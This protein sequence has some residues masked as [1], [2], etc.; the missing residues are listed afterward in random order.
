MCDHE[1]AW[2]GDESDRRSTTQKNVSDQ[3]WKEGPSWCW[4]YRL[5]GYCLTGT[6]GAHPVKQSRLLMIVGLSESCIVVAVSGS[7]FGSRDVSKP[8]LFERQWLVQDGWDG[9]AKVVSLSRG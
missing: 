4:S 8:V 1:K 3:H 5:L 2:L 7:L 6:A 9:Q